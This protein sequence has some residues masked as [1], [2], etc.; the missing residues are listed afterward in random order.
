M[1]LEPLC[2]PNIVCSMCKELHLNSIGFY[3]VFCIAYVG[4]YYFIVSFSGLIASFGI[5]RAV[6]SAIDQS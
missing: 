6:F 2:E 5:E 4:V 3:V 1:M